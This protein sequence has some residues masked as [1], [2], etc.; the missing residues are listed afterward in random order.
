MD[1]KNKKILI[2]FEKHMN[3]RY[4]YVAQKNN[5][6]IVYM[7]LF[8]IKSK[9]PISTFLNRIHSK[10]L[11]L[12]KYYT[13][14]NL[15]KKYESQN[16][17]II[18]YVSNAEGYIAH[19]FLKWLVKDF[20]KLELVAM[21]HGIMPLTNSVNK[22]K[23]RKVFNAI[24]YF[25]FGIYPYG[26][27]FGFKLTNKYIV[28]KNI[29][30]D[31]L[32]TFGW[33]PEDIIVDI[34]FLKSELYDYYKVNKLVNYRESSTAIFLPQCLALSGVCTKEEEILLMK[35]T[36][37]YISSKHKKVLIKLHPGCNNIGFRVPSNCIYIDSLNEGF[38][39]A[40]VAY[41]FFSTALLDA[42]IFE[43]KTI[44]IQPISVNLKIDLNVY[45]LFD[46]VKRF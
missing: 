26:T 17:K 4:K 13:L 12:H 35:K 38:L 31:I 25:I 11:F 22:I 21:Q 34:Q 40:N 18:I 28:Y 24:I 46:D 19:N 36:I 9:N 20:P 44:A 39:K 23:I 10:K 32:I 7:N 30:K 5:M 42:E 16:Y 27:G 1:S 45:S 33:N 6:K 8:N 37:K 29:Y 43:L 41:S 3:E 14:F 2:V 15:I